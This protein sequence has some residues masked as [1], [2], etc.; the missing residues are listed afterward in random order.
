MTTFRASTFV[1]LAACGGRVDISTVVDAAEHPDVRDAA[2]DDGSPAA[3]D[4]AAAGDSR[5]VVKPCELGEQCADYGAVRGCVDVA[6]VAICAP[7]GVVTARSCA[8]VDASSHC[9]GVA[10]VGPRCE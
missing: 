10:C 1:L 8:D 6:R 3:Q 2:A 4:A 9:S 5:A 7:D